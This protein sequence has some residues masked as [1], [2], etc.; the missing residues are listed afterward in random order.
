MKNNDFNF[1]VELNNV[2][3]DFFQGKFGNRPP[4]ESKE[5]LELYQIHNQLVNETN[6]TNDTT[7]FGA[8]EVGGAHPQVS[9]VFANK[10]FAEVYRKIRD[11]APDSTMRPLW[12]GANGFMLKPKALEELEHLLTQ[13]A[14]DTAGKHLKSNKEE[15]LRV[16]VFD[17]QGNPKEVKSTIEIVKQLQDLGYKVGIEVAVPYSNGVGYN[18]QKPNENVYSDQLFIDKIIASAKIIKE[19]NIPAHLCHISLKDMTGELSKENAARLIPNIINALDKQGLKIPLGLHLHDTGLAADAYVAAITACKDKNWYIS[20]DTVEGKETGFVSA[21]DLHQRL[22]KEGINL[23]NKQQISKLKAIESLSNKV[24]QQYDLI[25]VKE[26]LQGAELREFRIAGGAYASFS[27]AVKDANFSQKL[28]ISERESLLLAGNALNAVGVVMGYPFG[29]TP[30]FQNKQIAAINYLHNL[31]DK[32]VVTKDMN[33]EQMKTAILTSLNKNFVNQE[34][35]KEAIETLFL[36]GLNDTV[37]EFLRGEMPH[38]VNSVISQNLGKRTGVLT[39]GKISD[40]ANKKKLVQDLQQEG[41]IKPTHLQVKETMILLAKQGIIKEKNIDNIVKIFAQNNLSYDALD[42]KDNQQYMQNLEQIIAELQKK[43][44]VAKGE[45]NLDIVQNL[46]LEKALNSNLAWATVL[47]GDFRKNISYPWLAEPKA[48]DYDSRLEYDR[49]VKKF[50]EGLNPSPDRIEQIRHLSTKGN[51]DFDFRKELDIEKLKIQTSVKDFVKNNLSLVVAAAH[52]QD[53]VAQL[54]RQFYEAQQKNISDNLT[55]TGRKSLYLNDEVTR[56]SLDCLKD[57]IVTLAQ[58][59]DKNFANKI[60]KIMHETKDAI[61][62]VELRAPLAGKILKV[63]YAQGEEVKSGEV[64]CVIEAAKA[65]HKIIAKYAGKISNINLKAGDLVSKNQKIIDFESQNKVQD[66][67]IIS[68]NN[69]VNNQYVNKYQQDIKKLNNLIKT[70]EAEA[71]Q[72]IIQATNKVK[73]NNQDANDLEKIGYNPATRLSIKENG[74]SNEVKDA[75]HLIGNRTGCAVKL[76]GDLKTAGLDVHLTY[77]RDD[78]STAIVNNFAKDKMHL[79]SNYNDQ[80]AV[81]TTLKDL[82]KK[83]PNK[84]IMFHPGWGFLS[85]NDEFVKKVEEL[86]NPNI[87]F[88]GPA[89][90]EMKGAGNKYEFRN[91]VQEVASELNPPFKGSI[92]NN[93]KEYGTVEQL[94]AYVNSGFNKNNSLHKH[95]DTLFSEYKNMGS[96]IMIKAVA[97]GGGR[98]IIPCHN[99]NYQDFVKTILETRQT[100]QKLFANDEVMIEKRA[101]GA[102]QHIEMQMA[103]S[104]GKA[105]TLG[106]RNC[107]VQNDGQ[108]V[109]EVNLIEGDYPNDLVNKINQAS[110]NIADKLAKEGYKGLG[111]LEMLVNPT[112]KQ[113]VIL[114]VNTRIQVEHGVTEQDI[115]Q[116]TGR[117]ISLPLLNAHLTAPNA[118]SP[119]EIL[120][121]L[122]GI[123]QADI[124]KACLPGAERATHFRINSKILD[125]QQ[126]KSVPTYF[127]DKMW[128]PNVIA[129]IAKR[130]K[131][132]IMQ[133]GL[134]DGTK[135][136]QIGSI[137][138]KEEDSQKA[139]SELLNIF[140]LAQISDRADN[141]NTNLADIQRV[142]PLLYKDDGK[143]NLDFRTDMVDSMLAKI[144]AGEM[145]ITNNKIIYPNESSISKEAVKEAMHKMIM[146]EKAQGSIKDQ[147]QK[148]IF[149]GKDNSQIFAYNQLASTQDQAKTLLA[150]GKIKDNAI[151]WAKNQTQGLDRKRQDTWQSNKGNLTFSTVNIGK[152]DKIPNTND[153]ANIVK[154]ELSK[155]LSPKQKAKL[156][157]KSSKNAND[158]FYNGKKLGGVILDSTIEDNNASDI[159][160]GIGINIKSSPKLDNKEYSATSFKEEGIEIKNLEKLMTNINNS[161]T[162]HLNQ[163]KIVEDRNRDDELTADV[164]DTSDLLDLAVL[165]EKKRLK[166]SSL[167]LNINKVSKDLVNTKQLYNLTCSTRGSELTVKRSLSDVLDTSDLLDLDEL[168]VDKRLKDSSNINKVSKDLVNTEQLYNLTCSTRGSELSKKALENIEY[169]HENSQNIGR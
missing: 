97:G 114:E 143:I 60:S 144:K 35:E 91:Q 102:F 130:N 161:I 18:H 89:S 40:L 152:F 63:N 107:S 165:T 111:T 62:S 20:I 22:E 9:V 43:D 87:I 12:R 117:A 98:G 162:Q 163:G 99:K 110:K 150:Q 69:D 136:P 4:L 125:W 1:N 49:A 106:L 123:K 64:V 15:L 5:M 8:I 56:I 127:E 10:D 126:G 93:S 77:S 65:E 78:N 67:S 57:E 147:A 59:Q 109:A 70:N 27:K 169:D 17:S 135:D 164:L 129:Q 100:A 141:A 72:K 33:C 142:Y 156:K 68:L 137:L 3:R 46:I 168:P 23:L 113:V 29:V 159:I 96:D 14:N 31:V 6:L 88:A 42:G 83:N 95:Y 21:I 34:A 28:A 94:L 52:N 157:V 76:A 160:C 25:R 124:D 44:L 48:S 81:L 86:N 92:G 41:L 140:R 85:E 145:N 138:G 133:G 16:K 151:I 155:Y 128:L 116:K 104:N 118:K 7:K 131:V 32:G 51:L 13:L 66:L 36:S 167:G 115:K 119:Q 11:N 73:D 139:L 80:E 132:S 101:R 154:N 148:S 39:D 166:D 82:S 54:T 75:I 24:A 45:E 38:Q 50:Q 103:A 30:G 79:I 153:I 84:K 121:N 58:N 26:D 74:V 112:T 19:Q 37:R 90:K 105:V 122:Y 61:E 71:E 47:D 158:I 134:G 53:F 108:K 149:N 120:E 146:A 55:S 2:N